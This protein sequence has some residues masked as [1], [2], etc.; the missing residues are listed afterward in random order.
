VKENSILKQN[1]L[2]DVQ[3]NVR[4]AL[5]IV[6][7]IMTKTPA[8]FSC[9]YQSN[10]TL[11]NGHI[12]GKKWLKN[13]N[14]E[15][16]STSICVTLNWE[17]GKTQVISGSLVDAN[18]LA[19]QIMNTYPFLKK[20]KRCVSPPPLQ[21]YV[22]PDFTDISG[23]EKTSESELN[24]SRL[25]FFS[26][27]LSDYAADFL[28][29]KKLSWET[30]CTYRNLYQC[31][32]DSSENSCEDRKQSVSLLIDYSTFESN[33]MEHNTFSQFPTDLEIKDLWKKIERQLQTVGTLPET[34]T[35]NGAL[36]V[37]APSAFE[38]LF[39]ECILENLD[40]FSIALGKCSLT[41]S[42][43]DTKKYGNL[44]VTEFAQMPNSPYNR[45]FDCEGIASTN[46]S[47]IANGVLKNVYGTRI[48]FEELNNLRRR[49][50]Q[51]TEIFENF[52]TAHSLHAAGPANCEA[53]FSDCEQFSVEDIS[54]R[55]DKVIVV[56]YLN[57]M[58][59]DS[60]S[61]QFALDTSG[62]QV[63]QNGVHLGSGSF[64]VCGNFLD[65]ITDSDLKQGPIERT[66]HNLLPWIASTKLSCL[67]KNFEGEK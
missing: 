29:E 34:F 55:S 50:N 30:S 13:P 45:R 48:G 4:S 67:S 53:K 12:M 36:V 64:T 7:K 24:H 32:F 58:T 6:R 25:E 62:A 3:Q 20:T 65:C 1:T 60:I 52:G 26:K 42:D 17:D 57:G 40:S 44:N 18:G 35:P 66:G 38:P 23:S 39:S 9:F 54:K 49:E 63:Y 43:F 31:Y 27:S 61:T 33:Y 10:L 14:I 41:L 46:F 2:N 47:I 51:R 28:D 8:Q 15:A 56:Y 37:L 21:N 5:E 19:Q 16:Q 59:I 22:K 11:A